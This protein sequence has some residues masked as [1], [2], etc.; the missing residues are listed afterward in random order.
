MPK[1]INTRPSHLAHFKGWH[2]FFNHSNYIYI[3]TFPAHVIISY[4]HSHYGL[5]K[6]VIVC[7]GREQNKLSSCHHSFQFVVDQVVV[8]SL[9]HHKMAML[10]ICGVSSW[11]EAITSK[12]P[13]FEDFHNS[14]TYCNPL[15]F[16][17]LLFCFV[18]LLL[19]C[20]FPANWFKSST[21]G[22][23]PLQGDTCSSWVFSAPLWRDECNMWKIALVC[24]M[25]CD[26]GWPAALETGAVASL[27]VTVEL[28][29]A[30]AVAVCV[31]NLA[32]WVQPSFE[33]GI[34]YP[35][36]RQWV[37]S[38]CSEGLQKQ[39]ERHRKLAYKLLHC[40]RGSNAA[41]RFGPVIGGA[42]ALFEFLTTEIPSSRP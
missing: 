26:P 5:L 30:A 40:W 13:I 29:S 21:I 20:N 32:L 39:Q 15:L 8:F 9:S 1:K 11:P 7:L 14:G 42:A 22:G 2:I 25:S 12:V 10:L 33:D 27:F 31:P 28:W 3:C 37:T 6:T 23:A 19:F 35:H 38:A 34:I 36:S 24:V 16:G 17:Q 18:F 4:I 41:R